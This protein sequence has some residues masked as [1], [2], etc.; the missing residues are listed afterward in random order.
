LEATASVYVVPSG[1]VRLSARLTDV[2]GTPNTIQA[3]G[4]GLFIDEPIGIT[5]PGG[6]IG[7]GTYAVVYDECQNGMLDAE[8]E[9]FEPALAVVIPDP[10]VPPLPS[11]TA[12]KRESWTT[13]S[14]RL[15]TLTEQRQAAISR[16]EISNEGEP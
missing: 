7:P 3:V 9:V 11:R 4:G 10:N 16:N 12:L 6:R 1:S 15:M 5:R 2:A 8:D 13:P 14:L